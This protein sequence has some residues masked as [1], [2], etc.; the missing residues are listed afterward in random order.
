MF[1]K[2]LSLNYSLLYN[3]SIVSLLE[4]LSLIRFLSFDIRLVFH[5]ECLFITKSILVSMLRTVYK[6]HLFIIHFALHSNICYKRMKTH[7]SLGFPRIRFRVTYIPFLAV[8][9]IVSSYLYSLKEFNTF[10]NRLIS[11]DLIS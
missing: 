9:P 2:Y 4:K 7:F 11:R 6:F 5:F 8:F 3:K 1:I 10:H